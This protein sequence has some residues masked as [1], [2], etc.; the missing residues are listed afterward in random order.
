MGDYKKREPVVGEAVRFI[1]RGASVLDHGP[2]KIVLLQTTLAKVAV[3]T[4]G[5]VLGKE[6]KPGDQ[7]VFARCSLEATFD[8]ARFTCACQACEKR[9]EP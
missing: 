3:G 8:G 1:R 9:G 7:F 5:P 4:G 6:V 2:G